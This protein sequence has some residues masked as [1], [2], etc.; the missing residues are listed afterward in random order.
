MK[1]LHLNNTDLLNVD[2][3]ECSS[4]L[5]GSNSKHTIYRYV[6]IFTTT[7]SPHTVLIDALTSSSDVARVRSITGYHTKSNTAGSERF[8]LASLSKTDASVLSWRW[9]S[10]DGRVEAVLDYDG[11]AFDTGEMGIWVIVSVA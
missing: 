3:I 7:A 11:T 5:M 4:I 8:S 1:D 10:T 6:G 9:N 2:N